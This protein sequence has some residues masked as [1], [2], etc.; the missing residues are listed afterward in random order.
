MLEI[1]NQPAKSSRRLRLTSLLNF[2]LLKGHFDTTS[3]TQQIEEE[4]K[5]L[6]GIERF[7]IKLAQMANVK[8]SKEVAIDCVIEVARENSYDPVMSYLEHCSN[9][10]EPTFID[11]LATTYLRPQDA[12]KTEPTL[13]RPHAQMHPYRSCRKGSSSLAAST[14][15]PAS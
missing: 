7:Y 13:L 14:T 2:A 10:V 15:T 11:R 8:I 5:V 6:E 12:N 1:L 3:F 9:T 4:E